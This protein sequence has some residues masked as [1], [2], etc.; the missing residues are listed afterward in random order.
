MCQARGE[1]GR[2]QSE[3]EG[4][5]LRGRKQAEDLEMR[6]GKIVALEQAVKDLQGKLGEDRS[7]VLERELEEWRRRCGGAE[8]ACQTHKLAATE[9]QAMCTLA[10]NKADTLERELAESRAGAARLEARVKELEKAD[11][12]ALARLCRVRELEAEALA[13]AQKLAQ[14]EAERDSAQSSCSIFEKQL[15]AVKKASEAEALLRSKLKAECDEART[16]AV[17]LERELEELRKRPVAA[18]VDPDMQ[19]KLEELANLKSR[20]AIQAQVHKLQMLLRMA[21]ITKLEEHIKCSRRSDSVKEEKLG[22]LTYNLASAE[23][24][25]AQENAEAG[26]KR[27]A[28][29]EERMG[30][31]NKKQKGEEDKMR[32]NE[33]SYNTQSK[34]LK[35]KLRELEAQLKALP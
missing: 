32:T 29:R 22:L 10:K 31:L 12:E 21:E 2:K 1:L 33:D 35:E 25:I 17:G 34:R 15:S 14:V 6:D 13:A 26:Q 11:S 16:R 24:Q 4:L 7:A 8:D 5:Q 20:A 27:Q 28:V 9:A 23:S 19:G 18:G 3:L 30:V